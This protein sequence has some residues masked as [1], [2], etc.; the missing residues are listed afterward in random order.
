[1]NLR[2]R[3][4]QI[5]V[6]IPC[7]HPCLYEITRFL[8]IRCIR[9]F[10]NRKSFPMPIFSHKWRKNTNI[11]RNVVLSKGWRYDH[12]T[13]GPLCSP[14]DRTMMIQH[15]LRSQKMSL[16]CLCQMRCCTHLN[17]S[18]FI[19]SQLA[20]IEEYIPNNFSTTMLGIHQ[21]FKVRSSD[22]EIQWTKF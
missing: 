8:Y 5:D 14:E 19:V 6:Q 7:Q 22:E 20:S 3:Q 2:L 1:M 16:C 12:H 17:H 13:W 10:G 21:K 9:H 11:V 15:L 18:H 4:L